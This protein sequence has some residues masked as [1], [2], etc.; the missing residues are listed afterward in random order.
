[1]EKVVCLVSG[2]IDS[3]VA[4]WLI[5]RKGYVPVFIFYDNHPFTDETT[6]QRAIDVVKKLSEHAPIRPVK[7]YVVPHGEDLADILRNCPRN[8]TCILCRRMM[9]RLG[10]RIA[11]I[12]GAQAIV[13]GEIIGEHASQTLRNLRV[14]SSAISDVCILRPVL[15][16]D[17]HEVERLARE[18]GTF[19]ISTRP[20][21]CCSAPPRRPRTFARMEETINAERNL[22]IEYMIKRDLKGS[23][24][25]YT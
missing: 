19:E 16:F 2:G 10:E 5:F 9:Y 24:L 15:G 3:S 8:L 11:K 7:L 20:A 12:E 18:I 4:A 23:K 14:E 13:T 1:M 25:I 17:K 6:K 21:L 22:D